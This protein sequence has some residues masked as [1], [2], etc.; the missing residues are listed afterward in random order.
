M[1]ITLRQPS[2]GR[3]PTS[4]GLYLLSGILL[5]ILGFVAFRHPAGA[6]LSLSIW[7]AVI[8]LMQGVSGLFFVYRHRHELPNWGWLLALG[9]G[10][11]ALGGY[12]LA[13]PAAAL[14][15]LAFFIGFWLLFRSLS[16]IS[17]AF[18]LRR[19]SVAGW[20]WGLVSGLLGGLFG[21]LV[22]LNPGLGALG[23][24]LWLALALLALGVASCGLAFRL[25][26]AGH[27]RVAGV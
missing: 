22:L 3:A 10:E 6:Y 23:A 27:L 8:I 24:S 16:T 12:L 13:I 5:I 4:W 14:G 21:L 11:V 7:F 17:H 2:P 20:G 18:A 26:S 15:T 1:E 25:R 19:L 9:A